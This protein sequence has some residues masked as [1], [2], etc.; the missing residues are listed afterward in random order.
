MSTATFDQ[1]K[2]KISADSDV[3][4]SLNKSIVASVAI[5]S[6][7]VRTFVLIFWGHRLLKSMNKI[8]AYCFECSEECDNDFEFKTGLEKTTQ[9]WNEALIKKEQIR[10]PKTIIKWEKNILEEFENKIEN[11][12]L[13]S[14]KEIR[15]LSNSI[16][17]KMKKRHASHAV[18]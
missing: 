11:Y 4:G 1:L 6:V 17:E 13:A 9:S 10:F 2:H 12:W 14:D 7:F 15:D 8:D 3:V 18:H 16:S 5:S